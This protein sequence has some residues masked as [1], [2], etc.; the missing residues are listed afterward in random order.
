MAAQIEI[1]TALQ[2]VIAAALPSLPEVKVGALPKSG[3]ISAQITAGYNDAVYLN[4]Q[5]RQVMPVLLLAK[6]KDQKQAA[7][8]LFDICNT[9]QAMKTYRAAA[10]WEWENATT[11]TTPGFVSQE[12]GGLWIY[13]AILNI[14]YTLKE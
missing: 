3:G 8:W 12:D 6:H 14:E 1:V 11:A 9:L 13:S 5:A 2:E 7:G 10:G 4:K